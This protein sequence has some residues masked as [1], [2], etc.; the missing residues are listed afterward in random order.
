MATVADRILDQLAK[1]PAGLDDGRLAAAIGASRGTVNQVCRK[2]AQAGRLDRGQGPDGLILNR[3]A[4]AATSP[5]EEPESAPAAESAGVAPSALAE[6]VTSP[7]VAEPVPNASASAESSSAQ[8]VPDVSASVERAPVGSE[9]A[10]A[11]AEAVTATG[12]DEQ[13]VDGEPVDLLVEPAA[14][15]VVEVVEPDPVAEAGAAAV[16][17][18]AVEAGAA[19]AVPA[20]ERAEDPVTAIGQALAALDEAMSVLGSTIVPASLDAAGGASHASPSPGGTVTELSGERRAPTERADGV[21]GGSRP[22]A[23][24]PLP[25]GTA[26]S[27]ET[28]EPASRGTARREGGEDGAEGSTPTSGKAPADRVSTAPVRRSWW[29]RMFVRNAH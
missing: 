29:R 27:R 17:A 18:A 22:V 19:S 4:L 1:V 24:A 9:P 14:E 23:G 8:P 10:V 7:A 15:L 28:H 2:L 20:P 6:G 5:P 16:E 3:L 12:T 26:A 21:A 13:A 11:A 25:A